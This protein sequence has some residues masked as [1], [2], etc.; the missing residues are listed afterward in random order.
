MSTSGGGGPIRM[1]SFRGVGLGFKLVWLVGGL[2][3]F[4]GL[5]GLKGLGL[6]AVAKG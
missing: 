2:Y 5:E 4:R 1:W 3:V 6:R